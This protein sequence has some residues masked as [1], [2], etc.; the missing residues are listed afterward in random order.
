MNRIG[1]CCI[2]IGVNNGLKKK[3]QLLVNRGMIKKTFESKGLAY[4]SE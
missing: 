2:S 1:Y 4:V 3:D